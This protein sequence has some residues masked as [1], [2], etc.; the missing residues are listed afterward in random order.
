MSENMEAFRSLDGSDGLITKPFIHISFQRGAVS[1]IGVNGCRI[2]DVIEVLQNRLLDHQGRNLSCDENA[3]ALYHLE[4]AREAL[5]LRRRRREEQG[6]FDTR[7]RHV[8]MAP[9]AVVAGD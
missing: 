3:D 8:S 9:Q 6:V 7:Q 2:E 5:V 4:M 1:D